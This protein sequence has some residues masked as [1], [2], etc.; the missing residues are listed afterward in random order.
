[1]HHDRNNSYPFG[2]ML[3]MMEFVPRR[4]ECPEWRIGVD[5]LAFLQVFLCRMQ[6]VDRFDDPGFGS[7]HADPGSGNSSPDPLIHH[8]SDPVCCIDE[9]VSSKRERERGRERGREKEKEE[10]ERK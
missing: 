8:F 5:H 4:N 10:G 1:M 3:N 9:S 7:R 2:Y 6:F